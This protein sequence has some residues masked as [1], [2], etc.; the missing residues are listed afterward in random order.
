MKRSDVLT[1][2]DPWQV[3]TVPLSNGDS[4]RGLLLLRK[5]HTDQ[6]PGFK[7]GNFDFFDDNDV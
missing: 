6:M 4:E 1:W 3:F 2:T 7:P 5:S